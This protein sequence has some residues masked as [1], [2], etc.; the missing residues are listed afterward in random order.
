[1]A[2][3]GL[4]L[5]RLSAPIVVHLRLGVGPLAWVHLGLCCG[6]LCSADGSQEGWDG[7]QQT[8]NNKPG[9]QCRIK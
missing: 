4:D 9:K 6:L 2:L 5:N 1:M 8:I 3:G 7:L